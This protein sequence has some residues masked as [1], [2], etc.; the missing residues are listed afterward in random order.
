MSLRGFLDLDPV[1]HAGA[2]KHG[3]SPKQIEHARGN[4]I[5]HG[6][7]AGAEQNST[8][9]A[10][11]ADQNGR[12][13][14]PRAHIKPHHGRV[15]RVS[16]PAS[17]KEQPASEPHFTNVYHANTPLSNRAKRQFGLI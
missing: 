10:I 5:G 6:R 11:R 14:E 4:A 13:L 1:V 16:V 2:R 17:R 12:L 3:L 8:I 7:I 9:T 15:Y